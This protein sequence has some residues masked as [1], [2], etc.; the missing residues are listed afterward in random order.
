MTLLNNNPDA[1]NTLAD[2][3]FNISVP[4]TAVADISISVEVRPDRVSCFLS[5]VW[6]INEMVH[7]SLRH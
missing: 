6:G 1:N 2:N 5:C 3:S 4:V 7:I